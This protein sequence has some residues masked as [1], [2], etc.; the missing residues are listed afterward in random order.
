[1]PC[2]ADLLIAAVYEDWQEKQRVSH[3][4]DQLNEAKHLGALA[5]CYHK[6]VKAKANW[7]DDHAS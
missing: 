4:M 6:H 3:S 7:S 1:M 2:V 5:P